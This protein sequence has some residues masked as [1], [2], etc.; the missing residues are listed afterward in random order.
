MLCNFL[1]ASKVCDEKSPVIL[2]VPPC[3][4]GVISHCFKISS[5]FIILKFDDDVSWCVFICLCCVSPD[6]WIFRFMSCQIWESLYRYFFECFFSPTLFP[7]FFWNSG[8][9][10]VRSFVVVWQVSHSVNFFHFHF[11]SA[12]I[13]W[14]LLSCVQVPHSFICPHYSVVDPFSEFLDSG[15]DLF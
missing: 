10:R 15:C 6:S 7:F 3:R 11:L 1:V 12:Q 4:W 13:P 14:F 5:L 2:V 9:K 8:D